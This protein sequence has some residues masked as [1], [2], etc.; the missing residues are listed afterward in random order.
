[1]TDYTTTD[2]LNFSA[3]SQP[4]R[5][6]DAFDSVLRAKIEAQMDNVRANFDQSVFARDDEKEFD[7]QDDDLD[8]DDVDLD[9]DLDLD[10]LDDLDL[11]GDDDDEDA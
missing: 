9:D 11:D 10:D 2:I 1:M 4:L 8:L 7:P 3:A 6:A 5:V